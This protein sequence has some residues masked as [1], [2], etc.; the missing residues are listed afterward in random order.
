[1]AESARLAARMGEVA[2]ADAASPLVVMS[3]LAGGLVQHAAGNQAAAHA[4]FE[5][6]IARY[7]P[8]HHPMHIAMYRFDP[9]IF[10]LAQSARTF[11]LLGYADRALA[12]AQHAV[13]LARTL[14]HPASL[15]FA[16]TMLA[17]VRHFRREAAEALAIAEET[18]AFCDAHEIAQE[19]AWVS[20]VRGWALT[21]LGR[22]DEGVAFA[23]N[24]VAAYVATGSQH[25]LPYY[26]ALLAETLLAAGSPRDALAECKTGLDISAAIGEMAYDAELQRLRGECLL[27][28]GDGSVADAEKALDTALQTARA[29]EAHFYELRAATS[30]ASLCREQGAGRSAEARALLAATTDWFTEALDTADLRS[31]RHLLG[32]DDVALVGE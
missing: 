2:H 30:L 6:A 31:A 7:E 19:R 29:H 32:R 16:M 25:T 23:R 13:E 21:A 26:H 14:G 20:P 28:A 3:D 17:V 22:T 10:S 9:G 24:A 12:R 1:M 5:H 11:W 4:T 8:A 18:I 15:A 27:R